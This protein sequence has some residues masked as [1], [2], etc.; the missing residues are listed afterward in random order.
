M[1]MT[2]REMF[3]KFGLDDY[4]IDFKKGGISRIRYTDGNGT[5]I[6][7]SEKEIEYVE[8]HS[9]CNLPTKFLKA[10]NKQI[11]ELGWDNE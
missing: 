5:W 6:D 7:I 11:E 8:K 4:S 9:K 2:A 3:E 10:I 1:E